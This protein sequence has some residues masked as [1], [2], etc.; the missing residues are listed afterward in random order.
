MIRRWKEHPVMVNVTSISER[1]I[2]NIGVLE[3]FL[4]S[5][6]TGKYMALLIQNVV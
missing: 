1:E 3:R 4:T 2:E 5:L 6:S